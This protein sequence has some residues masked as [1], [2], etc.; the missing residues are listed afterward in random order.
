MPATA[1]SPTDDS[2]SERP[3]SFSLPS[4]ARS[5]VPVT[6]RHALNDKLRNKKSR[7]EDWLSEKISDDEAIRRVFLLALSRPPS[8]AE[9]ARF[10][11]LMRE[12]PQASRREVLEDLYWSVLT[13]REFLFNR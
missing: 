12:D 8:E 1:S 2:P 13:S 10:R 11:K 4:R 5:P 6:P 9:F 3:N 7:I